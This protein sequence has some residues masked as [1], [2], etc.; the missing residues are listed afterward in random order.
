MTCVGDAVMLCS[1]MLYDMWICYCMMLCICVTCAGLLRLFGHDGI[2][3]PRGSGLRAARRN[4]F[5]R[6]RLAL[7]DEKCVSLVSRVLA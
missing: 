4:V 7:D 2:F 1:I 5:C 6:G 3:W